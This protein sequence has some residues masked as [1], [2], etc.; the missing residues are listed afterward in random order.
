MGAG[1]PRPSS[2]S[3]SSSSGSSRSVSEQIQCPR[4]A[5]SSSASASAAA[6]EEAAAAGADSDLDSPLHLDGPAAAGG[7]AGGSGGL[8][9]GSPAA[10]QASLQFAAAVNDA[11]YTGPV[12]DAVLTPS[13]AVLPLGDGDAAALRAKRAAASSGGSTPDEVAATARARAVRGVLAKRSLRAVYD[14]RQLDTFV[15]ALETQYGRGDATVGDLAVT[16]AGAGLEGARA[17]LAARR[18]DDFRAGQDPLVDG[19]RLPF[20]VRAV[21]FISSLSWNAVPGT[22][23][24]DAKVRRGERE[25]GGK[26][27]MGGD[28]IDWGG[29]RSRLSAPSGAET[30]TH[31]PFPSFPL[32]P[33]LRRP[34]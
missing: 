32:P 23:G 14:D 3:S 30:L 1:G 5:S 27:G 22:K 7:R 19:A 28:T 11:P 18:A 24:I 8:R 15:A 29:M 31:L 4:D 20:D 26:G 21:T 34:P 13:G 16:G 25:R 17:S 6:G 12:M 10:A 2:S 33:L 9:G